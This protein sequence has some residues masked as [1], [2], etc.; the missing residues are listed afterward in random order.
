MSRFGVRG[1][2]RGFT[3]IEL[4]VVIAIIAVLIGLLVPAVQQVRESASRSSCG[5]NQHQL[6]VACMNYANDNQSKLPPLYGS[7]AGAGS[8]G[9]CFYFMLPYLENEPLYDGGTSPGSRLPGNAGGVPPF[10]SL[11]FGSEA[12]PGPIIGNVVKTYLCPSD[13]TNHQN[14]Y[15]MI[16]ANGPNQGQAA[17]S[18]GLGNYPANAQVFAMNPAPGST[19]FLG[20]KYPQGIR[21]GPSNTIF[22]G[23]KYAVCGNPVTAVV[24]WGDTGLTANGE[25]AFA[26]GASPFAMFQANPLAQNCNSALAQTPHRGGMVVCMGDG[27]VRTVSP[28]ISQATWQAALTP[29]AQD[30]LGSDW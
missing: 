16:W 9:S 3:L 4:L 5:N 2:G 6:G 17:G 19:S 8:W 26:Y 28:A 27:S 25:P 7:P 11:P 30:Q 13:P 29:N 22:F 24:A 21:D 23:E 14:P 1:R 12:N 20:T 10:F 15:P 18:W